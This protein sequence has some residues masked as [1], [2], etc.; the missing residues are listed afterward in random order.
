MP[1]PWSCRYSS[2]SLWKMSATLP[3]CHVGSTRSVNSG[4]FSVRKHLM[5]CLNLSK[6][7][8]HPYDNHLLYDSKMDVWMGVWGRRGTQPKC[9]IWVKEDT[10][11]LSISF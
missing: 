10:T 6:H 9:A 8:I 1:E 7:N 3:D 11:D 2:F 5:Y 4:L